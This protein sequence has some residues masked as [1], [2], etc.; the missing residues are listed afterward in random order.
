MS[1]GDPNRFPLL[2]YKRER[3]GII[4]KQFLLLKKDIPEATKL[5]KDLLNDADRAYT[6]ASK[7]VDAERLS[8]GE[9]VRSTGVR[10]SGR[11]NQWR[12]SD[13]EAASA[14]DTSVP[15]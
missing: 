8:R 9:T 2:R 13:I 3:A 5:L 1:A 7:Q 11:H 14:D 6:I 4:H 10:G 15:E 12:P